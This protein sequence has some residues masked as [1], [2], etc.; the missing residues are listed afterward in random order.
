M[1]STLLVEY[2]RP[3]EFVVSVVIHNALDLGIDVFGFG[4]S[5]DVHDVVIGIVQRNYQC[6]A[7]NTNTQRAVLALR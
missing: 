2:G 1:T 3:R 7:S 4:E 5:H 6:R